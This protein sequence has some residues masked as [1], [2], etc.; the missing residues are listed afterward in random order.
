VFASNAASNNASNNPRKKLVPVH[1]GSNAKP[2][3]RSGV[4]LAS[5]EGRPEVAS[6]GAGEGRKQ[7]WSR[8]SYNAY[9]REYM[10]KRRES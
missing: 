7:R 3:D 10:R 2:E 1:A 8:E 9:Q 5:G 4:V 6:E